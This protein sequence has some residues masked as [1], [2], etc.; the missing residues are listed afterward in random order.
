M[1]DEGMIRCS[2]LPVSVY[3]D[4]SEPDGAMDEMP[5]DGMSLDQ[6]EESLMKRY[7]IKALQQSGGNQAAAARMLGIQRRKLQYRMDKYGISASDFAEE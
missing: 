2:D 6:I 3:G 1:G 7:I 4:I 5:T